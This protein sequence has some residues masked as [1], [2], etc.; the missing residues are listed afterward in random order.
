[1]PQIVPQDPQNRLAQSNRIDIE[2]GERPD[3]D[4]TL[5][6]DQRK[7]EMLRL[8]VIVTQRQ[9]LAQRTVTDVEGGFGETRGYRTG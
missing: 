5:L 2:L 6:T 1:M 3:D 8:D 7:Q 9:R 4:T